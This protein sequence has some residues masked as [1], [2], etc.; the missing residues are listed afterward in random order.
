VQDQ[1]REQHCKMERR[2]LY[3]VSFFTNVPGKTMD[4]VGVFCRILQQITLASSPV[5]GENDFLHT[6]TKHLLQCGYNKG[7]ANSGQDGDK[8]VL[9][10]VIKVWHVTH[11]IG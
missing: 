4:L 7:L 6:S 3:P 1:A 2:L 10:V 11:K 8:L 5:K 9:H